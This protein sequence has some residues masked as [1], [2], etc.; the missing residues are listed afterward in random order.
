MN[1]IDFIGKGLLVAFLIA[2]VPYFVGYWFTRGM[3]AARLKGP[4][5]GTSVV[6]QTAKDAEAR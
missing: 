1:A 5:L 3:M 2:P 6:I 4:A